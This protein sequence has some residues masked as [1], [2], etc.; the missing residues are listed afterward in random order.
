MTSLITLV[1]N[2]FVSGRQFVPSKRGQEFS[3]SAHLTSSVL[4]I[5]PLECVCLGACQPPT[6]GFPQNHELT[7]IEIMFLCVCVC[8]CIYIYI[9]IYK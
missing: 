1:E 4:E 3:A 8:V 2:V 7:L 9:Y 6:K 5:F